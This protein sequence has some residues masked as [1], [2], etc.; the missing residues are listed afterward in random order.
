[1][2][3]GVIR[4]DLM[5]GTPVGTHLVSF[6]YRPGDEDTAIDNGRVV[7]IGALMDGER[8]VHT[9]DTPTAATPLKDLAVVASVEVMYDE[10][11]KNLDQFYNEA[12]KICRG[13]YLSECKGYFSVT[14]D[15]LEGTPVV[16][17]VVEAMAGTKMKVVETATSGSTQI[18]TIEAIEKAGRYTYVVIKL[19]G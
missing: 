15:D 1:M 11:L 4:T 13:Y 18:G 5:L 9:A 8:E 2:A 6:K 17:H 19:V 14:A 10:R 12:G 7:A 16:G 3:H